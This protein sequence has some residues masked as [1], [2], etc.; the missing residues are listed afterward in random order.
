[1]G[2]ERSFKALS[3]EAQSEACFRAEVQLPTFI[4]GAPIAVL[5]IYRLL[6]PDKIRRPEPDE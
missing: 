3:L 6:C 5:C 4:S 1:V 2:L